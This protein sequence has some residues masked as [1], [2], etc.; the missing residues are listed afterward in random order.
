M[1]LNGPDFNH[2]KWRLIKPQFA[3]TYMPEFRKEVDKMIRYQRM[4]IKNVFKEGSDEASRAGKKALKELDSRKEDLDRID[5]VEE[6]SEEEARQIDSL[7]NAPEPVDSVQT[8]GPVEGEVVA[9]PD[10]RVVM[11]ESDRVSDPII[12]EENE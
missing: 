6:L 5:H 3:K 12:K 9:A 2:I 7:Q 4:T 10:S 11:P 8:P 1:R